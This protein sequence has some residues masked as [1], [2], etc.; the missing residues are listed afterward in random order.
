MTKSM[1]SFQQTV[2][3]VIQASL[4]VRITK[5]NAWWNTTI[6]LRSH[7]PPEVLAHINGTVSSIGTLLAKGLDYILPAHF[8]Y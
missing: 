3:L 6:D 7:V 4:E 1:V 5:N 8:L 2:S